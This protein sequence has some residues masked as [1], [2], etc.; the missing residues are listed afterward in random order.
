M[1]KAGDSV[2]LWNGNTLVFEGVVY[3]VKTK[4]KGGSAERVS[5]T[6]YSDLIRYERHAVFRSYATGTKA[7]TIIKDLA[8]LEPGVDVTNVDEA[9]TPQ[10]TSPWQVENQIALRVMQDVAKGTNYWLRMK[11]GK[12]L[13]FKPKTI[14]ASK[15]TV[16]GSNTLEAEYSEDRW[17]LKNRV[18]YV[19]K[20]GQVLADVSEGA[21][22]M[23]VVVHDPF[24]TDAAEAQRRAQIRL[25]LSKEYGKQ[26][27]VVMPRADFE[28]MNADLFDTLTVN[29]PHLGLENVNMYIVEID[30]DPDKQAYT[31][32][33]GGKLEL[34]E[35]FLDEALGG[36]VAARFGQKVSIA[37]AVGNTSALVTTLQAALKIQATGKTVR[38]TNK[39]PLVYDSGQNITYDSTGN[40]ILMSGFTSGKMVWSFT[41]ESERFTT[42]ERVV[43]MGDNNDGSITATL[44]RGD[45]SVIDSNIPGNY[46][47]QYWPATRGE[48]TGDPAKW[49]VAGGTVELSSL[50]IIGFGSLKFTKTEYNMRMIY[51]ASMNLDIGISKFKYLVIY[52][53]SPVSGSLEV[54]LSQDENNYR[55]AT[56][57]ITGGVWQRHEVLI[58]SMMTVGSPSKINYISFFTDLVTLNIDSEYVLI[59]VKRE[60]VVVEFNFSRPSASSTSPALK[61]IKLV[62]R[63][64]K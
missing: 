30:Y 58:S 62:W 9:D 51:P 12:K 57:N 8:G 48:F 5:I 6:A 33:L 14:A 50:G 23:P 45:G 28:A 1:V 53:Y 43:W 21:G 49:S 55:K 27:R 42:W 19:G 59:P 13:Y 54:R 60:K 37:E 20:D 41:P 10:L 40:I 11:P 39:P 4:H 32:T 15:G 63:E 47:F 38:I 52:T 35:D 25:A 29:L 17:R 34:F 7:G 16:S 56:L 31:L 3:E 22:D 18:I 2:R 36:D 26:L 24:L 64:G 61:I 46:D 44:K